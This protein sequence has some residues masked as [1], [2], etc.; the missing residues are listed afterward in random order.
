MDQKGYIND[1]R[2]VLYMIIYNIITVHSGHSCLGGDRLN[3]WKATEN[4]WRW[5]PSAIIG[6]WVS[7]TRLEKNVLSVQHCL[8]TQTYTN[9]GRVVFVTSR[10]VAPW[11]DWLRGSPESRQIVPLLLAAD[12]PLKADWKEMRSCI[13]IICFFQ[14][15]Y[16]CA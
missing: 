14:L 3:A 6:I 7:T 8:L 16:P 13:Y 11:D 10:L 2:H 5:H 9:Y 4:N 12:K 1:Y 15:E